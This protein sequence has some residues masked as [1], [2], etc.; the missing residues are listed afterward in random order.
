MHPNRI[1]LT[2]VNVLLL[3]PLAHGQYVQEA[4]LDTPGTGPSSVAV[5]GDYMV[6]GSEK[7]GEVGTDVGIAYV[8]LRSGTTWARQATLKASDA[9]SSDAANFGNSVGMSGDYIV[10]GA[11][12]DN[13]GGSWTDAGA[14]YV[15]IRSG[16]TWAQQAKLVASDAASSDHFGTVVSISGDYV[17]AG[18]PDSNQGGT[19][20]GVAYVYLR[21]GTSWAQQAKLTSSDIANE[22]HIGASV[23][24]SG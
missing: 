10:V 7:F 16:T 5:S 2:V 11:Y 4:Q 18:S 24:I 14:A 3:L 1:C 8:Y 23:S 17:V 19:Q 9:S 12:L 22:D 21:S 15:F 20:K 13:H 6:A